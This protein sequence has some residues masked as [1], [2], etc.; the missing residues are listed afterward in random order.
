[1]DVRR[2]LQQ[3]TKLWPGAIDTELGR[4]SHD[5]EMSPLRRDTPDEA[6]RWLQRAKQAR[7]CDPR[8]VPLH[9]PGSRGEGRI[10]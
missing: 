4:P 5:F 7:R 10:G 6:F 3:A 8:A 2:T 1:M 9:E